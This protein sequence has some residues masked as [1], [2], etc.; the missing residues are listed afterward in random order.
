MVKINSNKS[1]HYWW[2]ELKRNCKATLAK[3]EFINI[4][5]LCQ[6]L[7]QKLKSSS[8]S[9]QRH[10]LNLSLERAAIVDNRMQTETSHFM[11][12]NVCLLCMMN[13][14]M[15]WSVSCILRSNAI[16]RNNSDASWVFIFPHTNICFTPYVSATQGWDDRE[17][18]SAF[19]PSHLVFWG[20]LMV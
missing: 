8:P 18:P 13:M 19:L 14:A 6:L 2:W 15:K 12:P 11:P 9:C 5:L 1:Y 7:L 20:T 17:Q 4:Y 10:H 16:G 3:Y